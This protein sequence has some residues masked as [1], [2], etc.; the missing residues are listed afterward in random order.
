MSLADAREKRDNTCKLIA[1]G[2]DPSIEKQMAK[3]TAQVAAE[4]TFE[5]LA[6]EW[7]GKQINKWSAGNSSKIK[8]RFELHIFPWLGHRP[9]NEITRAEILSAIRRIESKGSFDTAHGT[10]QNCRRVFRYATVIVEREVYARKIIPEISAFKLRYFAHEGINLHS[11]DIRKAYG[12]FT[13][14]QNA[15][16]RQQFLGELGELMASLPLT[17]FATAIHKIP[18]AKRYGDSAS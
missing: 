10:L 9:I 6:M 2:T 5:T 8:R 15:D 12:P 13:I 14:L 18:Y 11:R 3:R 4:N 1:T 16:I 7:H 17:L